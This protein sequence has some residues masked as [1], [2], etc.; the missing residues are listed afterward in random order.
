MIM[1]AFLSTGND[2]IRIMFKETVIRIMRR[3]Q[4]LFEISGWSWKH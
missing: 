4:K 2:G 1:P 3:S